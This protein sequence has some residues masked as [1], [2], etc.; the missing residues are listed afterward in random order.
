V[1]HA[2]SSG[3]DTGESATNAYIK[4]TGTRGT[5]SIGLDNTQMQLY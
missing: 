4:P 2:F 5:G 3:S 1:P